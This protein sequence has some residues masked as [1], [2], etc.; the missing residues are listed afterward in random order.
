MLLEVVEALREHNMG[1]LLE[2]E[3]ALTESQQLCWEKLHTG[4]ELVILKSPYRSV[5]SPIIHYIR[6]VD[7]ESHDDML[8]VVIP[9]FV[10]ARW[11]HNI[12]HN[13]TAFLIRTALMF[14]ARKVVTS[15]RYHLKR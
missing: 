6:A 2:R 11:W 5:V 1:Q 8:T 3:K 7:K 10:A 4:L 14:E 9:E 13:Q 15:V 12:F